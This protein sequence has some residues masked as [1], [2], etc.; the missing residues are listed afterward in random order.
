MPNVAQGGSTTLLLSSVEFAGGPPADLTGVTIAIAPLAAG[1]AVIGPTSTGISH[2]ATGIYTYEWAVAALQAPGDY[3]VTWA[4]TDAQSEAITGVEV[5]TVTLAPAAPATASVF[6]LDRRYLSRYS[7]EQVGF[8]SIIS[9]EPADVDGQAVTSALVNAVDASLIRSPVV[10]RLG[11]GVYAVILT[12]VD[13][14]LVRLLDLQFTYSIGGV[15]GAYAIEL[16]V[17]PSAPDYDVLSSD[18]KAVVEA[19]WVR[20]ADLFDSPLG[21]PNLQVYAQSRFGRNR[22]A[23]LLRQAVG[24]LNTISQPH[25]TYSIEGDFPFERWGALAEQALYVEVI[26]HLIRS[27]VEQP[28]VVLT[29]TVSRLDRRDYMQRWQEML[30][31]EQA[32]LERQLDNFKIASLNL[33]SVRVLVSG[34]AFGRLGPYVTVGGIGQ[35]AARGYFPRVF[36]G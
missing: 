26:K 23:Q 10:I 32:D 28:E 19:T 30:A 8:T 34:G 20:F 29:A 12:S 35:A 15:P 4:G 2:P 14:A 5:V 31:I 24:R 9:G 25:Q 11:T 1:P 22:M 6:A 36:L 16:Q 33:S 18:W 17:G 3:L 27:Y 7:S 21:G 13:T